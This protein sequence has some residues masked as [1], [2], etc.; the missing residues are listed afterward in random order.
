MARRGWS[1]PERLAVA[2]WGDYEI[3]SE[4]SPRITTVQPNADEMGRTAIDMVVAR[5]AGLESGTH[6]TDTGFEIIARA[7]TA[8]GME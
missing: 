1:M 3:A 5:A 6:L 2:G 4:I 7:S 8:A